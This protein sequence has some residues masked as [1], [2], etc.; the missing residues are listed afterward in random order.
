MCR[1]PLTK[2]SEIAEEV[3]Y[4]KTTV[5]V[6]ANRGKLP[7]KIVEEDGQKYL[8]VENPVKFLE[9]VRDK[10]I[11]AVKPAGSSVINQEGVPLE[12]YE[13]VM[14]ELAE[15]EK[16]RALA[17]KESWLYKMK[18]D[19]LEKV[20]ESLEEEKRALE[21][22]VERL[23]RELED[24]KEEIRFREVEDKLKALLS[25]VEKL[26]KEEQKEIL[27]EIE[28]LRKALRG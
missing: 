18:A 12:R 10:F 26:P 20:I 14:K 1:I 17:E 16:E 6:W 28:Q 25:L 13:K 27:K 15:C 23:K 21:S 4:G 22:Q 24:L 7:G 5:H 3:G 9:F 2:L 11:S 8:E 19:E